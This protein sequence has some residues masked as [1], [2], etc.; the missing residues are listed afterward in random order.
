M[1]GKGSCGLM[2]HVFNCTMHMA[3]F[4]YGEN[5]KKIMDTNFIGTTLLD[6]GC[7]IMVCWSFCW[8]CMDPL[9]RVEQRLNAQGYLSVI[10]NQVHPVILTRNF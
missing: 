6:G 1:T 7:N 3:D 10:T 2:Y 8:H 5:S 9:I 4:G